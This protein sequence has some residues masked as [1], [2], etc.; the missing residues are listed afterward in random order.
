MTKELLTI[1]CGGAFVVMATIILCLVVK[2]KKRAK[3]YIAR[4]NRSLIPGSSAEKFERM[5]DIQ[6]LITEGKGA[7]SIEWAKNYNFQQQIKT[8]NYLMERNLL[9]YSALCQKTALVTE[10]YN[11]L[12][13]KIAPLEQRLTGIAIL[14]KA[15]MNYIS[16]SAAYSGYEKSGFSESFLLEHI[17]EIASMRSAKKQIEELGINVNHL[18]SLERIKIAYG[19]TLEQKNTFFPEYQRAQKEMNVIQTAKANYERIYM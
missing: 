16:A 8:L 5:I 14:E 4:Q 17:N 3:L 6:A 18:P 2:R 12:N 7:E 9:D 15:V 10:N 19:E 13:E 1:T 11:T